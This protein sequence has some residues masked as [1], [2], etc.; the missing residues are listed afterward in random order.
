[1]DTSGSFL[2]I[3]FSKNASYV[4]SCQTFFCSNMKMSVRINF[5]VNGTLHESRLSQRRNAI[6]PTDVVVWLNLSSF[7]AETHREEY[8]FD[9]PLDDT[10]TCSICLED[11]SNCV[12]SCRHQFH[13]NC[14]KAWFSKNKSCPLCRRKL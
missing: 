9:I 5:S 6:T 10:L 12:L 1:M 2:E 8:I 4:M 14:I 7:S 3:I 13:E 11:D